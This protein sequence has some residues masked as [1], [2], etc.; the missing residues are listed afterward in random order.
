VGNGEKRASSID[1]RLLESDPTPS[2]AAGVPD[3]RIERVMNRQ[4]PLFASVERVNTVDLLSPS[5]RLNAATPA[6]YYTQRPH[7]V[8]RKRKGLTPMARPDRLFE[9]WRAKPFLREALGA[10]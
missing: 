2:I 6:P 4:I 1:S 3:A 7:P 5:I 9:L 10:L 8:K